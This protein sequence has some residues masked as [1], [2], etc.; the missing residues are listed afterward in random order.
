MCA[1]RLVSA[2]EKATSDSATLKPSPAAIPKTRPST[3][4]GKSVRFGSKSAGRGL[5]ASWTTGTTNPRNSTVPALTPALRSGLPTLA[6]G[7]LTARSINVRTSPM[8]AP[9]PMMKPSTVAGSSR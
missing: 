2:L 9:P 6:Y 4:S 5:R 7:L 8:A 1:G 3:V